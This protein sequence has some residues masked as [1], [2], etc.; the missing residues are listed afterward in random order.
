MALSNLSL[1]RP[2]RD[3]D[4]TGA[5]LSIGDLMSGL[6]MLFALLLIVTLLQLTKEAEKKQNS[7][8]VIIRALEQQLKEKGITAEVD[9]KTGD[10]SILDSVLFDKNSYEL[11]PE[12]KAFLGGFIPLYA[13]VIDN[14]IRV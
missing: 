9:K 13:K 6:L 11:K 12:G 7:R 4:E 8:I 10:I 14:P 5:W 1:R 2:N 3:I